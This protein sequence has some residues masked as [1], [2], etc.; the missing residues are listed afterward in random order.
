MENKK[1]D[2]LLVYLNE[3]NREYLLKGAKKYNCDSI[4]KILKF[5]SLKLLQKIRNKIRIS[6]LGFNLYQLLLENLQSITKSL[7]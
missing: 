4:L 2:L 5:K 3:F 1:N 6:I 7:K